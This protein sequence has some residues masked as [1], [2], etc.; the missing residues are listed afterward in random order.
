MKNN[1]LL[2]IIALLLVLIVGGIVL[3]RKNG[4]IKR[5]LTDFAV[6]DT[7]S[8][9]KIYMADR[10]GRSV[11]LEKKGGQWK[12]NGKYDVRKDGIN[13]LLYTI[14]ALRM[15][16]PVAKAAH[17]NVIKRL[18]AGAIKTEIYQ[19]TKLTKT[20]YVGDATQDQL[21]TFM[22]LENSSVPFVMDIP[23]FYG[24]LTPRYFI[25]EED[26][27]DPVVMRYGPDQISSVK[28]VNNEHPEGSFI[29][30][31]KDKH[32][33]LMD[34]TGK[35]YSCP[36]TNLKAYLL[37]YKVVGIQNFLKNAEIDSA[38]K[39]RPFVRI[40]VKDHNEK[41]RTLEIFH[42]PNFAQAIDEK[43]RLYKYDQERV[44]LRI[45][46][47]EGAVAQYFVLGPLIRSRQELM[48]KE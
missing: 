34:T 35:I 24:Y 16:S 43:G 17:N 29:I 33:S 46:G 7:A 32:F 14:Y 4:T 45:N 6:K 23:G 1:K 21:G 48:Q 9:D 25:E 20:Y 40:E 8:I 18:A 39:T 15:K 3:T 27:R 2:F 42:L 38:F 22:I 36:E 11:L 5:E 41:V 10:K 26:W 44:Y 13:T 47:A 28:L 37:G 30:Q 12:V 31:E 19:H